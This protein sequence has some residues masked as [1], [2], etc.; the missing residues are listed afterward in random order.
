MLFLFLA[1]FSKTKNYLATI[2]ID[3]EGIFLKNARMC[4]KL[5]FHEKYKK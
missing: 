4:V 5:V 2:M 3:V 1:M